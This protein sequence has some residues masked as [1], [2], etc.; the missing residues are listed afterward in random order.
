[1]FP[2]VKQVVHHSLP[3]SHKAWARQHLGKGRALLL[4]MCHTI[5]RPVLTR[6]HSRSSMP[7]HV[8]PRGNRVRLHARTHSWSSLQTSRSRSSPSTLT[9]YLYFCLIPALSCDTAFGSSPGVACNTSARSCPTLET[10]WELRPRASVG[11]AY[12]KYCSDC[13][14]QGLQPQERPLRRWSRGEHQRSHTPLRLHRF[15]GHQGR[16]H[17]SR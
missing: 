15:R 17:P 7:R 10:R 9:V 16:Q 4:A 8:L 11:P 5:A 1:M 6:C 2:I 12:A 14:R 3:D 13:A